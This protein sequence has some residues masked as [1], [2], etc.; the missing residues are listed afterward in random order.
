MSDYINQYQSLFG[1]AI[2]SNPNM[3]YTQASWVQPSTNPT[4]DFSTGILGNAAAQSYGFQQG[5]DSNINLNVNPNAG[6][7][8]RNGST[9]MG[10]LQAAAGLWG[11]FNGMQQNKLA[12]QQMKTSIAQWNK[13]YANQV[14]SYN[15]QLED[16]QNARAAANPLAESTQSYMQRNRLK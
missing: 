14:A 10:G 8:S 2:P 15:T 13:N 12:K 3:A 11:A 5:L 16:R 7:L 4:L 6:F 1:S 9:I